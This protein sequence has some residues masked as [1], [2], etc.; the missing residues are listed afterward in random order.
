M[1]C[2]QSAFLRNNTT[3]PFEWISCFFKCKL[4]GFTIRSFIE[5]ISETVIFI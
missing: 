3:L 1:I 5:E 4:R 2:F